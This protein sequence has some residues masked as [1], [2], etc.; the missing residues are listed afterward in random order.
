[1]AAD[2][3]TSEHLFD[4]FLLTPLSSAFAEEAAQE[5]APSSLDA[6]GFHVFGT[7]LLPRNYKNLSIKEKGNTDPNIH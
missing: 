4:F 7:M 6:P 5:H 1:M 2:R 3:I